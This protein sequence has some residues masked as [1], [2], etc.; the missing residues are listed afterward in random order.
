MKQYVAAYIRV[1]SKNQIKSE[2]SLI[3]QEAQIKR[4]F[5]REFEG[6]KLKVFCEPGVS[7]RSAKY[8]P[9]FQAMFSDME[10]GKISDVIFYDMS[11][12]FRSMRDAVDYCEKLQELRVNIHF[13]KYKVNTSTASGKLFFQILMMLAEFE[14]SNLSERVKNA[15]DERRLRGVRMGG[16]F[17]LGLIDDPI[18]KGKLAIYKPEEKILKS[19]FTEYLKT[20]S[21]CKVADM[22]NLT[23]PKA[24]Q[25][26]EDREI[27]LVDRT[28]NPS[29]IAYIIRNKIY[30]GVME[31]KNRK[32]GEVSEVKAK[33][34]P[35]IDLN[36]FE[37]ANKLLNKQGTT[38]KN[39]IQ[40]S[41]NNIS[42]LLSGLNL[43]FCGS[44]KRGLTGST[45]TQRNKKY[46]YY[47]CGKVKWEAGKAVHDSSIKCT[48]K[49]LRKEVI[50]EHIEN[51][52]DWIMNNSNST[53]FK[54]AFSDFSE[55]IEKN[56]EDVT[57]KEDK[58]KQ[59]INRLN[60]DKDRL[61]SVLSKLTNQTLIKEQ[62]LKLEEILEKITAA[63]E[64]LEALF[65]NSLAID[66]LEDRY[67]D[68]LEESGGKNKKKRSFKNLSLEEKRELLTLVFKRIELNKDHSWKFTFNSSE[69]ERM[70]RAYQRQNIRGL[71]INYNMILETNKGG[72]FSNIHFELVA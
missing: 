72:D 23:Y 21:M 49:M 38:L 22:L 69:F 67:Q 30:I 47:K 42:Y 62:N 66:D 61:I 24:K 68:F 9:Q 7:G 18:N 64:S 37:K 11:R 51:I 35:F 56:R 40:N 45:L 43:F 34:G 8:R 31:K 65:E 54:K 27:I 36:L 19:V 39:S 41:R 12:A 15:Y 13:T 25:Y 14:S 48:T 17:P 60:Q 55:T 32:T 28:W 58:I 53:I 26:T 5:D 2:G 20:G 59:E 44:C 29:S 4:Y 1:S 63:E 46:S 57:A 16:N 71:S 10:K 3:N 70:F 52:M 50:E 33:F 6:H